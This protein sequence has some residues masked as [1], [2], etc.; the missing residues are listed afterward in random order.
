M[1][2][3]ESLCERCQNLFSTLEGLQ[4]LIGPDGYKHHNEADLCRFAQA[5]CLLCS[6][7]SSACK[8]EGITF[9]NSDECIIIYDSSGP[10]ER[11]QKYLDM[12]KHPLLQQG[13]PSLIITTDIQGMHLARLSTLANFGMGQ[14][15][16]SYW[17]QR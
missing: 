1:A 8:Q 12:D 17:N 11:S 3:T 14:S 6:L 15:L 10:P 7:I 9:R 4:A 16:S 2:L 13:L 5:G